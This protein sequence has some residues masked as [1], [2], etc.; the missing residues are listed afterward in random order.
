MRESA[1]RFRAR[2]STRRSV[3]CC[4][5]RWHQRPWKW[6]WPCSAKFEQRIE[7][8]ESL[9][10]KQVEQARYE[11]EIAKRRFLRCDPD[12]RL[13]AGTLEADW[14]DKLRG[15]EQAQEEYERQHNA[16]RSEL[17]QATRAKVLALAQDFPRVWNDPRT[18]Q[19]ERKRMLALLIE[20]VTLIYADVITVH[21][22]FR[23]GQTRTLSFGAAQADRTD[24]QDQARAACRDRSPARDARGS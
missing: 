21:I 20:D 18:A 19:R 13:V 6:P 5:R 2:S 11:A 15:L 22:R 7:Q 12:N 16:A 14:N 3:R 23:G 9:R 1:R 24:S 4:S 17:D 10:L 8:A